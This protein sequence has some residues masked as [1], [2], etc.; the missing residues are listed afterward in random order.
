MSQP[1]SFTPK[2]SLGQNFLVNTAV[3][4][5]IVGACCLES[6]DT[7]LEIGP[8]KGAL[9]HKLSQHCKNII[10]IEKDGVLAEQLKA[11]FKNSNVH[12]INDDILT[13]SFDELPSNIK[14][15]GN[16][17]YNIATP[18]IKKIINYR[19]KFHKLY[20]TVQLE[21]G[22]RLVAKP[23]TKNYGSFSCFVQYYSDPE[24]LFKIKNSAFQPIPKVQSCFLSLNV[25]KQPKL[26]A[27]NENFLFSII[28]SCFGQ[29]RK[30][31]LNSLGGTLAKE[32]IPHLLETVEINPKLRAENL[33]LED[34]IRISNAAEKILQR[35]EGD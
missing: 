9:T 33:S 34:Y 25:H 12:I 28:R 6:T 30:M 10:A 32:K 31:I 23:N 22:Q 5:R 8:G 15:V 16:L 17:P 24:I 13:Y 26:K 2:K 3:A 14:I 27:E 11:D 20:I 21:Y 7:V 4:D 19:Q 1:D 29:R 35:R 18:I